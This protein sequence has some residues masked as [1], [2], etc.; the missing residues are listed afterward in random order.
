MIL[1]FPRPDFLS[2]LSGKVLHPFMPPK[3]FSTGNVVIGGNY[4]TIQ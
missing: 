2:F 3:G 4:E 1:T